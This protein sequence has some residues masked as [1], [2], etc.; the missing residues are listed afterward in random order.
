MAAAEVAVRATVRTRVARTD[1]ASALPAAPPALAA[2][3]G[4][5]AIA[6][7]ALAAKSARTDCALNGLARTSSAEVTVV[8]A[9]V[10]PARRDSCAAWM[11]YA[12]TA[13][14]W[15]VW[16]D[17]VARTDAGECVV[18]ARGER[19]ARTLDS[20]WRHAPRIV[21]ARPVAPTAA[22]A[23]VAS[24]NRRPRSAAR[25]AHARRCAN[26]NVA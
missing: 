20:V 5:E 4:A 13:A 19:S 22:G 1:C 6:P 9:R 7:N 2:K 25:Q 17:S 18:F 16:E 15:L 8:A 14:T 3:T 12:R 26:P 24:A 21:R 23:S 11:G 10:E